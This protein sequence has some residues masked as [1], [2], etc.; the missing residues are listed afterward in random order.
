[1]SPKLLRRRLQVGEGI[2][3]GRTREGFHCKYL[4]SRRFRYLSAIAG[5][6]LYRAT[7]CLHFI[8]DLTCPEGSPAGGR[9]ESV[10]G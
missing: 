5:L 7:V 10:S 8:Y 1:M 3:I 4:L 9:L 6:L 2:E